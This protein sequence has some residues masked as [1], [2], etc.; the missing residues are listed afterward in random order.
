[1]DKRMQ[2]KNSEDKLYHKTIIENHYIIMGKLEEFH[3][4]HIGELVQEI[5]L[6]HF[7]ERV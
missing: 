3:L 4:M 6:K 5:N 7:F 2:C 1:M